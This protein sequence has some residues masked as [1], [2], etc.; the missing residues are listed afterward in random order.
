LWGAATAGVLLAWGGAF[1]YRQMALTWLLEQ[2]IAVSDMTALLAGIARTQWQIGAG[3]FGGTMLLAIFLYPVVRRA[4]AIIRKNGDGEHTSEQ[5]LRHLAHHDPLT[6]LANR[7]R[8]HNDLEET[9]RHGKTF[10]VMFVD[11]DRFKV[12]N[13]SLGHKAGDLVLQIASQRLV[14][15]M[16]R[17]DTVYRTG[18]DEFTVILGRLGDA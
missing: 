17:G 5:R 8:F 1:W 12:V 7:R 11:L 15:C 13:D 10:G 9:I 18:G 6:Q 14:S 3:L 16:R 4:E 2:D